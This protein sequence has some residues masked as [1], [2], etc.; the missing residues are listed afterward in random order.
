MKIIL[1]HN[2]NNKIIVTT[3]SYKNDNHI[4]TDYIYLLFKHHPYNTPTFIFTSRTASVRGICTRIAVILFCM[5][6]YDRNLHGLHAYLV[7]HYPVAPMLSAESLNGHSK[8]SDT[9]S[10]VR[11]G[12]PLCTVSYH[13][14]YDTDWMAGVL[15]IIIDL[16]GKNNSQNV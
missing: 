7:K 5:I 6:N 3:Q 16:N 14:W 2:D 12:V 10:S 13:W 9:L 15:D 11:G 8:T 4:D 1:P